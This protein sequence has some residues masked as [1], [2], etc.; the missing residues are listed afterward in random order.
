MVTARV[1]ATIRAGVTATVAS[2][3]AGMNLETGSV[4]RTLPSSISMRM[5]TVVTGLVSEASG[6]MASFGSGFFES[7][8]IT[9]RVSK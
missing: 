2:A 6:K 3:N 1:A 4:R 7:M 8:S 5:A 9:P